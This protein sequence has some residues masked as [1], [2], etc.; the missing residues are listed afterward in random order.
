[1]SAMLINLIIQVVGGAIGGNIA[2]ASRNIN[3]GGLGNTVSGAI[4]GGLGG[5]IIGMFI[6]M[7]SSA[8]RARLRRPCSRLRQERKDDSIREATCGLALSSFRTMSA[9]KL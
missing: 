3:L 7:L 2:G 8:A 4:G 5:Q 6:P 1:M 9:M